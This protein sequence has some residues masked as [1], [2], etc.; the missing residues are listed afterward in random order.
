MKVPGAEFSVLGC[1]HLGVA[2]TKKGGGAGA[3]AG[4]GGYWSEERGRVRG[5]DEGCVACYGLK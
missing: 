4:A 2:E 5:V 1:M 3:G